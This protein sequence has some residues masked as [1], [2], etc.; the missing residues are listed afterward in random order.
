MRAALLANI[1]WLDEELVSLK[2]LVAGLLDEQVQVVQV[3][4]GSL[5]VEESSVFSTR[6]EWQETSWRLINRLKLLRLRPTLEELEVDLLHALDGRLWWAALHLSERLGVPA[7]LSAS[8]HFDVRVAERLASK[9]E[10]SRVVVTAA[11]DPLA[12]AITARLSEPVT[13]E[14]IPPGVH[15][16]APEGGDPGSPALCAIVSGNGDHDPHYQA[17]LQGIA[18]LVEAHPEAQFFFDNQESD[19]H[20]IWRA[21]E[22]LDLLPHISMVPRRLGHR[23]LLLRADV[24]IQPQPLGRAR[25]LTLRAMARALPVVAFDDPWLDYLIDDETAW[26]VREPSGDDWE[27]AMRRVIKRPAEA[28]D[29][30]RRAREW[31]AEHRIA[32]DSVAHTLEVYRR[33]TGESIKFPAHG[34]EPVGTH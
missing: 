31:V 28:V 17:L 18:R 4:P 32:S 2:H 33:L 30:G 5:E 20:R 22:R 23:E 16:A 13:V 1:A 34:S 9:I 8:S 7:V 12:R 25:S 27:S 14:M 26:L 10:P 19:Q 15:K 3:V 11:T 6:V 29:L 24:L 21:A